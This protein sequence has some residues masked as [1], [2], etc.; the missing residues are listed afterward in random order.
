MAQTRKTIEQ[1]IAEEEKKSEQIKARV[2]E[3]RARQR[4]EDR[5]KDSHRKIVVGAAVMAHVRIDPQFRKQ[6]RDALNKA[7]TEPKQRN[8]I[9]DLLDE[10]VGIA[11]TDDLPAPFDEY[12]VEAVH[13]I[14][15]AAVLQD[16][17][18][19][20]DRVTAAV[21]LLGNAFI[22]RK[23]IAG[24]GVMKFPQ[25]SSQHAEKSPSDRT[26]MLAFA[27]VLG[28]VAFGIR[29]Y[30]GFGIPVERNARLLAEH[31]LTAWPK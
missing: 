18:R 11:D 27:A 24:L 26:L 21:R 3:L 10:Q 31:F 30:A 15:D 25:Q 5:K 17:D 13:P 29:E 16:L 1:L 12:F 4:V 28:V 19:F 8:V 9:A 22:A 14:E 23:A 6:V 2:A 20:I 7:V